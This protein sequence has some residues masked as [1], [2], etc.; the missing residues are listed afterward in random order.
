MVKGNHVFKLL[1]GILTHWKVTLGAWLWRSG[2]YRFKT[3]SILQLCAQCLGLWIEATMAV[4]LF[5]YKHSC[6]SYVNDHVHGL[7]SMRIP[8]F[9]H[10]KQEGL[11]QSGVAAI[12]ASVRGPGHWA[13]N[14]NLAYCDFQP[15]TYC[16]PNLMRSFRKVNRVMKLST[17][18]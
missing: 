4:T 6:C 13:H 15:I 18:R 5:S 10:Q 3:L 16:C 1:L 11:W 9:A 17:T 14:C 2:C 8:R 7:V 12:L